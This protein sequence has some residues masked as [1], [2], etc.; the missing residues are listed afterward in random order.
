MKTSIV[1][2]KLSVELG[3]RLVSMVSSALALLPKPNQKC[4]MA[5]ITIV[6]ELSMKH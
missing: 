1:L 6:M 4:A 5:K 3:Q 2:A